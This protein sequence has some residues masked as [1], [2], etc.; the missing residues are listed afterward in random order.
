MALGAAAV[1]VAVASRAPLSGGVSVNA[2]SAQ[3]PTIA[4]FMVLL[5]AGIVTLTALVIG[6]WY[7]R[8]GKDNPYELEP[9]PMNVHWLVKLVAIL[10]PLALVVALVAAAVIGSSRAHRNAGPGTGALGSPTVLANPSS[11]GRG[12]F[13]VPAWFPWTAFGIVAVAAAGALIVLWLR[14]ERRSEREPQAVATGAAVQAAIDALDAE[15]D[16]RLAVIAAYGAM[17]RTLAE[18]GIARSPAEAPREYLHRVLAASRATESEA[19]TLTSLFEEARYS[20]HGI[21]EHMRELALSALRLLRN[22]LG[23]AVQT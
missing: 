4:L 22:R 15:A 1:V 9:P 8:R 23:A 12:G 16:P 19:S 7:T 2:R 3:A 18:H 20:A 21:P 10:L 14:R 13:V 11:A 5:A 6:A 17:Q